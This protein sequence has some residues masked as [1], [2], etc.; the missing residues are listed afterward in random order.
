[1]S[2]LNYLDA[3]FDPETDFLGDDGYDSDDD[4][5]ADD[6]AAIAMLEQEDEAFLVGA[7]PDDQFGAMKRGRSRGVSRVGRK[8]KKAQMK[9]ARAGKAARSGRY[10]GA[11]GAMLRQKARQQASRVNRLKHALQRSKQKRA[12]KGAGAAMQ[13]MQDGAGN[14]DFQV[15][16]PPGVGRLD[17][18]G[19]LVTNNGGVGNTVVGAPTVSVPVATAANTQIILQTPQ[20]SW[21]VC[22]IVGVE[23]T[24]T[25]NV[26]GAGIPDIYQLTN[27]AIGGG[28]N[29]LLQQ[30]NMDISYFASGLTT[31]VGLRDYPILRSPNQATVT[32]V[33]NNGAPGAVTTAGNTLLGID[34]IVDV[35]AD[36]NFGAHL[37]GP[38]ARVDSLVR[39]PVGR[40]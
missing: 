25:I 6:D 24:R 3:G 40:R 14:L 39:K 8:L 28:A 23:I 4:F 15:E 1:M 7:V 21:A 37:P 20:I 11:A 19:F 5:G 22:R 26:P 34:L 9:K 29:L 33:V 38:Y 36:D 12:S 30:G 2:D 32:V 27:F 10:P 17:R 13:A 31:K 18:M 35:L 16:S